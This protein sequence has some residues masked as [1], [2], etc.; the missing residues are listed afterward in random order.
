MDKNTASMWVCTEKYQDE[1]GDGDWENTCICS[2]KQAALYCAMG[3]IRNWIKSYGHVNY[4]YDMVGFT[5]AY[6]A[7][8]YELAISIWNETS[9]YYHL[10][11]EERRVS[12]QESGEVFTPDELTKM[13]AI[14]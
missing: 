10:E 5:Q 7:G 3:L 12:T 2:T 6:L 1:C 4:D 14:T 9:S 13:L 8:D 11:L